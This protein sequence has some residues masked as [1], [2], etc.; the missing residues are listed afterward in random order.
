MHESTQFAV[1]DVETTGLSPSMNRVVQL[2]IVITDGW[3][4]S[5]WEFQ[6]RFNPQGPVGATHVHGLTERDVADAPLFADYVPYL[7]SVLNRRVVVAHKADFDLAF[8]HAEFH[9]AGW[10]LPSLPTVCTL[11]AARAYMPTLG[12]WRLTDCCE[13]CGIAHT[14]AHD[15]LADARA[16]AA[17]LH[18]LLTR[19]PDQGAWLQWEQASQHAATLPWPTAPSRPPLPPD[20]ALPSHR[21]DGETP[22]HPSGPPANYPAVHRD[23]A[24]LAWAA[25]N[26]AYINLADVVEDGAP[27]GSLP[28]LEL[29][30]DALEDGKLR[31]DERAALQELA[32]THN[33]NPDEVEAAH[34]SFM[35]ALAEIALHDGVVTRKERWEL[36]A[37]AELLSLDRSIVK[38]VVDRA[39]RQRAE[40]LSQ[41]L[42]D[43]PMD[44]TGGDPLRVGD[45]VVF[46]GCY[47]L[48][49]GE[50]Q[51]RAE[52]LGVR[53][54][55]SVSG[56]VVALVTDGTMDGSKA[57]AARELGTR[58]IHPSELAV[59]LDYIQPAILTEPTKAAAARQGSDPEGSHFTPTG[60]SPAEVRA[61]A[62]ERRM[63]IGER[64]R[65]PADILIAYQVAHA[66]QSA[67]S[68]AAV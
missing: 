15:A 1:L 21:T 36:E 50:L 68:D 27:A 49:R 9:R 33:L 7:M 16:A 67:P 53:V 20:L 57:R 31:A 5:V 3:G 28:Y 46:T 45:R 39:E 13:A 25:K 52:S 42:R 18:Q 26:L 37:V 62:R 47:D 19:T 40:R 22:H 29:L 6:S 11:D 24:S 35:R 58:Q 14:S 64:G 4:N 56:R 51:Q 63:E 60:P 66:A 10:D 17:F 48:G 23:R 44:W 54:V 32:V 30:T 8:L 2:G 65:I 12:R 61:W 38:E 34:E 41:G 59:L 55:G 43:L